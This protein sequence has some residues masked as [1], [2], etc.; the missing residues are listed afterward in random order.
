MPLDDG[1][2]VHV[3]HLGRR[4]LVDL[5]CGTEHLQGP[6]FPGQPG[7]HTGL[8]G[9]EIGVDED[10]PRL[11]HES[12]P[13]ELGECGWDAAIAQPQPVQISGLY[14]LPGQGQTL[15]IGPWQVLYLHQPSC[16]PSCPVGP[17][18]LE[19]PPHPAVRTHRVRQG[20]VFLG[21]GLSQLLP[22][23]KHSCRRLALHTIGQQPGYRVFAQVGQLFPGLLFH[24]AGKLSHAV[25]VLEPG[26]RHGLLHQ[27]PPHR[28]PAPQ[29]ALHQFQ[30]RGHPPQV[31]ALVQLP[32]ALH[33]V[34]HREVGQPALEL[35]LRHYVLGIVGLEQ[36]PFCRVVVGQVPCPAAV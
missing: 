4:G 2:G 10:L 36:I 20:V 13:D 19:Q 3:E 29:G 28:V 24:P 25:G 21:A 18:E 31:D 17:I 5:P 22:Y 11:R 15:Q 30:I 34:R 33:L 23:F 8:D 26:Q 6:L 7:E 16:L 35:H 12:G 27:P 1:V 9:G 14:E 32:L